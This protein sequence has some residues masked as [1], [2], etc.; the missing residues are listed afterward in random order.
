MALLAPICSASETTLSAEPAIF[1]IEVV[2]GTKA[3]A[4]VADD[5]VTITVYRDGRLMLTLNGIAN[6][7]G[8]FT[9][10][11]IPTGNNVVVLPRAKHQDM[12]FNG[13]AVAITPGQT[14]FYGKVPVYDVSFDASLISVGT[15]HFIIKTESDSVLIQEYMQLKNSSDMAIIS[16]ELDDHERNIV[17]RVMLPDGFEGLSFQ[18]YFVENAIVM[19][20]DGFYDTMAIP[21]GTFQAVFA[22]SIPIGSETI[23]ITKEITLPTSEFSVFSQ[24]SS[25]KIQGLGEPIG[26]FKLSN[27]TPADY[28]KLSSYKPGDKIAFEI[29]GFNVKSDESKTVIILTVVFAVIGILAALRLLGKKTVESF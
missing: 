22:Y 12:S 1:N 6:S 17:F 10:E 27:E 26:K 9:F 8:K 25:D 23:G 19:T 16:D 24:L 29:T 28:F 21:P 3:G 20:D 5:E 2:N 14:E 4:S 11:D 15:H 18:G 13:S 7:E